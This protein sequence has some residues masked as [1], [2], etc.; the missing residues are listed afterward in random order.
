MT[1]TWEEIRDEVAGMLADGESLESIIGKLEEMK[2]EMAKAEL[3]AVFDELKKPKLMTN[4]EYIR[5]CTF[6]E[7]AGAIYEWYSAGYTTG[8]VGLPLNSITEIVEWL[9]EKHYDGNTSTN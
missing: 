6:E 2:N 4:E 3:L 1:K 9:K 7:L 8:R 5:S